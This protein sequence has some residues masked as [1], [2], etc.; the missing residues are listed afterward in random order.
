MD[1]RQNNVS[2]PFRG[3]V[4]SCVDRKH[5]GHLAK[6]VIHRFFIDDIHHHVTAIHAEDLRLI[7]TSDLGPYL[8]EIIRVWI[9]VHTGVSQDV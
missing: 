7:G 9:G 1:I 6:E 8:V 3:F 2:K 5:E 4:M